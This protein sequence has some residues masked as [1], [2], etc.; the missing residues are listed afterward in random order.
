MG[1]WCFVVFAA[2]VILVIYWNTWW[3]IIRDEIMKRKD[4]R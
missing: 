1:C 4:K 3:P 2:C